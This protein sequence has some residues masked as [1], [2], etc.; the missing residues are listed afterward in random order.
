MSEKWPARQQ[1][2]HKIKWQG[3]A[4]G[5]GVT[6]PP[7]GRESPTAA[8]DPQQQQAGEAVAGE[9]AGPAAAAVATSSPNL[10]NEKVT[11]P[12]QTKMS[13]KQKPSS[14]QKN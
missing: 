3:K 11:A 4:Q 13:C 2:F 14:R 9:A 7:Q 12:P 8:P 5:G 1:A 10:T 6:R